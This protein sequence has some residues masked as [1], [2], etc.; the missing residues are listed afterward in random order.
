M[1]AA[2]M[3]EASHMELEREWR[4]SVAECRNPGDVATAT[5][6]PPCS[7]SIP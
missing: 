3:Y 6:H 5:P 4:Q 2:R 7:P 1:V